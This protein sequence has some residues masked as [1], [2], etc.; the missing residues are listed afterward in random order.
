[1]EISQSDLLPVL[2]RFNPWWQGRKIETLPGW[3]RA[4]FK[5]LYEWTMSPPAH[6]AVS[7]SG[8]R[9]IGKTTLILQL[10]QRMLEEGVPPS[11]IIYATMDH[12][13]LKLAGIDRV[14]EAWRELEPPAGGMEYVFVDEIQTM[15]DWGTWVK[16]QVDFNKNRRIVFTGSAMTMNEFSP[17]SGVGRWHV[18][19]LGTLSFYEYLKIKKLSLDDLPS[20]HS[21][22]ELFSWDQRKFIQCAQIAEKY[23][24]HFHEYLLR[25]GF[26]Q[27]ALV[28]DIDKAQRLVREDIV[29]KV[30][31][32]DM[33]AFYGVRNVLELESTFLYLCKHDGGILD[34]TAL[35]SNLGV[36]RPTAQ[37]YIQHLESVH[38]L[39]KLAPYGYGKDILRARFKVYLADASI[40]P[41]VWLQ[42]KGL[43]EDSVLLGQTVETAVFKH[44]VSRAYRQNIGFSYWKNRKDQEVDFI[45]TIGQTDIPFEVKYREQHTVA[46]EI[47]G[48]LDFIAQKNAPRGYVL[49]KTLADFGILHSDMEGADRVMR[50]PAMLFC[51]WTGKNEL[52]D[53]E[54]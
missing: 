6:R 16:L 32:R 52:D 50:I 7:L 19:K 54:I 44:L 35:C 25:G 14:L 17:E 27:T 21:L 43:L 46:K 12:P 45:G 47:P 31:K 1:M 13:L 28:D 33:T 51:W 24:G 8:A 38:L 2:S 42:G 5:E 36:K 9:Q 49:T 18:C 22:A 10:I 37:N 41:A 23:L 34:M 29:D 15:K 4:A 53:F 39:K 48:L 40:A 20:P 26:P 3:R 30:L 11:N